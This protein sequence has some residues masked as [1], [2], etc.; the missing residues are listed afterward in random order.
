MKCVNCG[1]EVGVGTKYCRRCGAPIQTSGRESGVGNMEGERPH[2]LGKKICPVCGETVSS[3]AAFCKKCG[4]AFSGG[5]MYYDA[6]EKAPASPRNNLP[7]KTI[8]IVLGVLVLV[9]A[10]ILIGSRIG[11][12]SEEQPIET[13][14][15]GELNSGERIAGE[16]YDGQ[17]SETESSDDTADS[18]ADVDIASQEVLQRQREEE[19]VDDAVLMYLDAYLIDL[20]NQT[21]Y[22]LYS[23][24]EHGSE[25]ERTQ[26]AFVE[27][28]TLYEDRLSYNIVDREKINSAT[29]HVTSIEEYS[30]YSYE[31]GTEYYVK[32][33][34]VYEVRNQ[35]NNNWKLSNYVGQV[36]QLDKYVYD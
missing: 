18:D 33:K 2:Q 32:Q 34:C 24:I 31:S 16:D 35:G 23:A 6:V 15:N 25:L 28:G 26:K 27:A 8:A 3:G 14:Q 12:D 20:N 11:N 4:H 21:Y 7:W 36:E 1:N 22:E 17:Q 19:A 30:V 29:Y 10:S 13:A 5:K 9:F